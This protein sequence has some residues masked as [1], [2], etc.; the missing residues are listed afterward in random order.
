MW[1]KPKD[2]SPIDL[3]FG[4]DMAKLLPPKEDIPKEFWG[5]NEWV[6]VTEQWFY[7]GLK[8]PVFIPKEGI[9]RGKALHHVMAILGS[10]DPKHE[11]KIAGVAFLLSQFFEKIEIKEQ[12]NGL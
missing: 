4:G 1:T 5:C 12:E 2:V 9:D 8:K 7:N 3:A 10:W 6:K 11:H